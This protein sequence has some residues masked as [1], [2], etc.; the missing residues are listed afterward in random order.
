MQVIKR[1]YVG[2]WIM[3]SYAQ[4]EADAKTTKFYANALAKKWKQ[5]ENDDFDAALIKQHIPLDG[6]NISGR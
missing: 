4:A 6:K 3:V 2:D 1:R 5:M